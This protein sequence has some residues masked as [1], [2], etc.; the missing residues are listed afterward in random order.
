MGQTPGQFRLMCAG[1]R[2]RRR[3]RRKPAAFDPEAGGRRPLAKSSPSREAE[4]MVN[5]RY[6]LNTSTIRG[7]GLPLVE[8]VQVA[9]KAGYEAIEPWVA[10]VEQFVQQG[11]RIADLRKRIV[12]LGLTVE[13]SVGFSEWITADEQDPQGLEAWKRDLDLIAQL[14]AKRIAAP[15]TGA[16]HQAA[17]DLLRVAALSTSAGIG[18]PLRRGA[19]SRVVGTNQVGAVADAFPDG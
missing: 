8:E 16:V 3:R 9:A 13:S 2:R 18:T 5:V 19:A 7:Q 1:S 12:D 17:K 15:P 4:R 6:C 10:E 11:G 14:G